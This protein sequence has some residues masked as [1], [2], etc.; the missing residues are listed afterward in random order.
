MAGVWSS[1]GNLATPRYALAG[2]G[3]QTAGL[4]TGGYKAGGYRAVTEEY[5]EEAPPPS[6]TGYFFLLF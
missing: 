1:G 5:N 6:D 4:C 3:T 2:A